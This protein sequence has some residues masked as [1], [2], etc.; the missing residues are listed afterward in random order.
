M[1]F[2]SPILRQPPRHCHRSVG[3]VVDVVL[4]NLNLTSTSN[5]SSSVHH[6]KHLRTFSSSSLAAA[7]HTLLILGKP[8]GGKGTI[9]SKILSD[10]PQFKHVSTGDELRQHVRNGTELG[11][12]A[13]KFMDGTFACKSTVHFVGERKLDTS[14]SFSSFI[15]TPLSS[16]GRTTTNQIKNGNR[17]FPTTYIYISKRV[18]SF[19]TN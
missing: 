3:V 9:S 12:Q 10:F 4:S 1:Q 19:P 15:F 18:Y 6:E 17:A 7:A 16:I 8:G 11:A 13:K 5:S 2:V 14:Y